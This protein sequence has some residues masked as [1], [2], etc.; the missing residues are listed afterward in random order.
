MHF[1]TRLTVTVGVISLMSLATMAQVL[2][3]RLEI[4]VLDSSGSAV[5]RAKVSLKD[6]RRNADFGAPAQ[7]DPTGTALFPSV[8]PSNTK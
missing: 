1:L 8:R 7:S 3:S 6:K 4:V 5:P 2:N